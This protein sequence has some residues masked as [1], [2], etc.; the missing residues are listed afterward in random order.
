MLIKRRINLYLFRIT[1]YSC[2]HL[3][4]C[5]NFNVTCD[6][7]WTLSPYSATCVKLFTSKKSWNA[8]RI[9]CQNDGADLIKI[10]GSKMNSFI[11]TLI[12]SGSDGAYIGFRIQMSIRE[13]RWLDEREQA[14]YRNVSIYEDAS[15]GYTCGRL[16]YRKE[17]G[18]KWI[19]EDCKRLSMYIC[20]KGPGVCAA[21]WLPSS[22]SGTCLKVYRDLR[23]F[24]DARN[25]C[26]ADDGDLV[27]IIDD[28]MNLFVMDQVIHVGPGSFWIG[29]SD[30]VLKLKSDDLTFREKAQYRNWD[31]GEPADDRKCTIIN[32]TGRRYSMAWNTE[33]CVNKH[34]FIC[35]RNSECLVGTYGVNCL[36]H[37]SSHCGGEFKECDRSNGTCLRGKNIEESCVT[38]KYVRKE[39]M[40]VIVQKYA[41]LHVP[42]SKA[43]ITRTV[44]AFHVSQECLVGTY[45]VNCLHHCSSHC[46]GEFKECDRR[47]GTCLRGCVVGYRGELCDTVCEKGTYGSDCS[48]VCSPTCA[49]KQGCD[50][51]NGSCISCLPGYVGPQCETDCDRGT[52]GENCLQQC[53]PNC[54]DKS[55]DKRSGLCL[56]GCVNG[57]RGSQC[58]KVCDGGTYG[59]NCLQHCSSNCHGNACDGKHGM[60]L[61][62]CVDKYKGALCNR[63]MALDRD[64]DDASSL[65]IDFETRY[66]F[67]F[68]FIGGHLIIAPLLLCLVLGVSLLSPRAVIRQTASFR[69]KS[70]RTPRGSSG[71]S[72]SSEDT[73]SSTTSTGT[74]V[75]A[76]I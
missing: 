54:Q 69:R 12:K 66:V 67:G 34:Y 52:Y 63:C 75:K 68:S 45:G 20:E 40:E 41:V 13:F 22:A 38:Q 31:E 57:Y 48:K 53:S 1:I 72:G 8:S 23:D 73:S 76:Y 49:P 42:R 33:K 36:H 11:A 3:D 30:D 37:C 43:V 25:T 74:T 15:T 19:A 56:F 27:T 7:G 16:Y 59:A 61:Y 39:H 51:E 32:F 70:V 58:N 44:L 21:G 9:A 35:E 18:V 55:C 14:T 10:L 50:N 26:I 2:L 29:L 62:G 64:R 6:A 60:C 46:G 17:R 24:Q 5:G 28:E 47:N 71:I 4:A 65:P